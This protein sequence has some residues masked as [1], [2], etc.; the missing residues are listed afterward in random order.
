[1]NLCA[2]IYI[3]SLPFQVPVQEYKD[4]NTYNFQAA[5]AMLGQL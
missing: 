1:M 2:T 5:P 4:W 3:M